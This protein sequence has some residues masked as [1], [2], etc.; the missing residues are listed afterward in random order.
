[1]HAL[2]LKDEYIFIRRVKVIWP[3]VWTQLRTCEGPHYFSS[4]HSSRGWQQ[5]NYFPPHLQWPGLG[6]LSFGPA[7]YI[8]SMVSVSF[9]YFPICRLLVQAGMTFVC[10][11]ETEQRSALAQQSASGY[12][13]LGQA[14]FWSCSLVFS[15]VLLAAVAVH[16]TLLFFVCVFGIGAWLGPEGEA[17]IERDWIF[18]ALI[19]KLWKTYCTF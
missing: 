5:L 11:K 17:E 9:R 4:F 16:P 3:T 18:P 7:S 10:K 1:M 6:G 8:L 13:W 15:A 14:A 19:S 12:R 2:V